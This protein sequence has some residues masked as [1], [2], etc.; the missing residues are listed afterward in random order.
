MSAIRYA[1][2][3]KTWVLR[4]TKDEQRKTMLKRRKEVGFRVNWER[5]NTW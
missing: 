4:N 3:F 5:H 2:D 1:N